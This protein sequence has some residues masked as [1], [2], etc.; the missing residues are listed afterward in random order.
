MSRR[1]QDRVSIALMVG[2]WVM[3]AA[4]LITI[5]VYWRNWEVAPPWLLTTEVI[6]MGFC[7]FAGTML[8]VVGDFIRWYFTPDRSTSDQ[9]THISINE[10]GSQDNG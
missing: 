6:T 8:A 10:A 5:Q 9:N 7:F 3:L 4:T 1:A 2:G